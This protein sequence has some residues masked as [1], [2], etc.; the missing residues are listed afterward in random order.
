[1]NANIRSVVF[2]MTVC[3][4][5]FSM[6]SCNDDEPEDKSFRIEGIT[7]ENYPNVDCSTSTSPL[8]VLVAC[9]LLGLGYQWVPRDIL[10]GVYF[11]HPK[12]SDNTGDALRSKLQQSGTHE[13]HINLID[14]NADLIIAAREAS[15]DEMEY[16]ASKNVELIETPIALDAFVFLVN[17]ENP[18]EALTTEQIQHIYMA[19][20]TNWSQVGGNDDKI[21][22]YIRDRNS[23]SQV[24]ME[25]I[26]MKGLTMPDWSEAVVEGMAGPFSTVRADKNGICYSVYYYKEQMVRANIVKSI[27]VDGIYPDK[28]TIKNKSYPYTTEIYVSIRK[29]LDKNSMAYKLYKLLVS[30]AAKS[31][32]EES[33][34]VSY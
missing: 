28:K 6:N 2:F 18:I 7:A 22:P 12:Y 10:D 32:I 20:T 29:D 13:S 11:I 33:G 9:K 24:K 16:A 21:N 26:V 30:D 34:Y 19:Q 5:G 15:D 25:R 3:L 8:Q 23:G 17:N 14:G 1:M 4:M 31:V 27:A